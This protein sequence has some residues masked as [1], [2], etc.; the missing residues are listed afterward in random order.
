MKEMVRVFSE[1]TILESGE[2][3][4]EFNHDQKIYS[5]NGNIYSFSL[6]DRLL[7]KL[8]SKFHPVVYF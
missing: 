6:M 5:Y 8:D 1:E 3:L 2:Y 4:G 7:A